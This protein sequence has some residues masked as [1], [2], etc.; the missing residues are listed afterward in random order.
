VIGDVLIEVIAL[1]GRFGLLNRG[2]PLVEV[3]VEEA[4]GACTVH[5]Q[6]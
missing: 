5:V 4:L 1:L 6:R 3:W 2:G